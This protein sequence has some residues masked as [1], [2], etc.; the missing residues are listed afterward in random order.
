MDF[1]ATHDNVQQTR[2]EINNSNPPIDLRHSTEE[3]GRLQSI[4]HGVR[5]TMLHDPTQTPNEND[6]SI[7]P[8]ILKLIGKAAILNWWGGPVL[9]SYCEH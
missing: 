2:G 5:K 9:I 4:W 7:V 6:I 3:S 8:L 1:A